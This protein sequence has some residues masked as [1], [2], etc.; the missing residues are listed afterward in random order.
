MLVWVV[1]AVLVLPWSGGL[2]GGDLEEE[3]E[4]EDEDEEDDDEAVLL[5]VFGLSFAADRLNSG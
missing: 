2:D 5:L 3:E 4:D 1:P